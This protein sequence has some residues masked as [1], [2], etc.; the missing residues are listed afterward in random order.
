M[1]TEISGKRFMTAQ[2][3]RKN[4][5]IKTEVSGKTG[6]RRQRFPEKISH[7]STGFQKNWLIKADVSGKTG[8]RRQRFPKKLDH[9]GRGFRKTRLITR[10]R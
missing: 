5:H 6:P 7:D 4:W 9:Y 2:V 1:T 8:P 3:S 10:L